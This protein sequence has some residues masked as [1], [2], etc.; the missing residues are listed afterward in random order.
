M[1]RQ[2]NLQSLWG[3]SPWEVQQAHRAVIADEV[4][5]YFRDD[6]TLQYRGLIGTGYSGAVILFLQLDNQRRPLNKFVVKYS[7]YPL[8]DVRLQNEA[9]W[10]TQLQG[11]EHISQRIILF[12]ANFNEVNTGKRPTLALRYIE[13][14]TIERFIA[15]YK[16][17]NEYVPSRFLWRVLACL[18]Q[19]AIAMGYPPRRRRGINP[20][21]E[22][23]APGVEYFPLNQ[24]SP[25]GGNLMF[26]ELDANDFHH[27]LTPRLHL[28]D[29]DRASAE[30]EPSA[31]WDL[32]LTY[33]MMQ[34]QYITLLLNDI[35]EV[36]V[37]DPT[38]WADDLNLGDGPIQYHTI[39]DPRFLTLPYLDLALRN[40]VARCCAVP[41]EHRPTIEQ[42]QLI[43]ELGLERDA[44]D[45]SGA[46][47]IGLPDD[48][49][50]RELDDA[51]KDITQRY[52]LSAPEDPTFPSGQPVRTLD[53]IRRFPIG[54][55]IPHD[56]RALQPQQTL[57]QRFNQWLSGERA[58][59]DPGVD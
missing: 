45:I 17:E 48:L 44:D 20:T 29:F 46:G 7:L 8:A 26:G 59:P 27:Q 42:L 4:A 16:E 56:P 30:L 15:R 6:P 3:L 37:D 36:S 40:L 10:L 24:N 43:V 23:I 34:F 38:L 5:S 13:N 33:M 28:I 53:D 2:V 14:G 41:E 47:L 35:S 39:A 18:L 54:P 1:N 21:R 58:G 11:A 12:D 50:N 49:Y 57:F 51:I 25:H 32:N 19:H 55:P 9:H 52:I 31:A 22:N